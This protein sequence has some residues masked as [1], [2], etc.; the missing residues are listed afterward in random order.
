MHGNPLGQGIDISYNMGM[1]MSMV[2]GCT[3]VGGMEGITTHSSMTD[4]VDDRVSGTDAARDLGHR[5]VDGD[6]DGQRGQRTRSGSA[7]TATTA[8]PA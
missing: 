3:V 6:G 1:G 7:S 8:R 4:I 2:E 5:D